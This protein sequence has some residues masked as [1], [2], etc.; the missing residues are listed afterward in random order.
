MGAHGGLHKSMN[1]IIH[2]ALHAAGGT[3][4]ALYRLGLGGSY[5]PVLWAPQDIA[6]ETPSIVSSASDLA[7]F[8]RSNHLE[9][10]V[11]EPATFKDGLVRR[12]LI[13]FGVRCLMVIPLHGDASGRY[14]LTC[15]RSEPFDE[16]TR[17][18]LESYARRMESSLEE[19]T[20][21]AR[22]RG[23]VLPV[24]DHS[25]WE[26]ADG[27]G[28]DGR[29][30]A[31]SLV[32][33]A[34]EGCTFGA[35]ARRAVEAL[36]VPGLRV[37]IEDPE[38]LVLAT[39]QEDPEGLP[40]LSWLSS[41]SRLPYLDRLEDARRPVFVPLQDGPDSSGR[42]V[43]PL[44]GTRHLLGLVSAYPIC[45]D[46][47][48]GLSDVLEGLRYATQYLLRCRQAS[49]SYVLRRSLN[50]V[51]N[52]RALIARKLHDET[53]QNLVALKVRLATAHRAIERGL[54]DDAR[55][56]IEDCARIS[57]GLLDG[58]NQLAAELRPSELSYLGLRPAIE[59]AAESRLT[60]SGITYRI[61]GNAMD[62]RFSALQE[63]MFLSGV[64]EALANCASH[65][66]ATSV[67]VEMYEA[68]NWFTI[69]VRDD[70][71]GFDVTPRHLERYGIKAMR[72]C[73]EAIGG[74]FWIGSDVGVGT[75]VRFSVPENLLEEV[76]S[77]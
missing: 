39:T 42:L 53:S 41:F 57:D 50:S 14:Y 23:S 54:L 74:S 36:D 24:I 11:M 66:N 18:L 76:A 35:L 5:V 46:E 16:K 31:L 63:N 64:S 56:I 3:V 75:T 59:A 73:I 58:V 27:W 12:G 19:A 20:L 71:D 13:A 2:E 7:S 61:T 8:L 17:T 65:S 37:A 43:M 77:E 62:A 34:M 15:G 4:T 40:S 49:R 55:G 32:D 60:R 67:E 30:K 9:T 47:V 10:F 68:G 70:G 28:P 72:D 26:E 52:D 21:R 69:A 1:A 44:F 29:S 45:R 51:E 48:V 6:G 38:G 22:V 25:A 33:A